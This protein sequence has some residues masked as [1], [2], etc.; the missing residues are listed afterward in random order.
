MKL[1]HKFLFVFRAV[2]QSLTLKSSIT[3]SHRLIYQIAVILPLNIYNSVNNYNYTIDLLNIEK[4][5]IQ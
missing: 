1:F 5:T 2:T 3:L 4:V